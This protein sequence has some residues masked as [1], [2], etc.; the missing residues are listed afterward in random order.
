MARFKTTVNGSIPFTKEE[1]IEW[2]NMEAQYL[3]DSQKIVVPQTLTPRQI[4]MQLTNSGLRQQVEDMV[5]NSNDYALKD[6][7]EYSIDYNRD[8]PILKDMAT[9]LG[10]TDEQL[11]TMFIEAS[12]L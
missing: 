1:E 12:R 5:A 10:L 8:N 11:D 7:W 9:Q 3:I 2:D 6:W 4:R